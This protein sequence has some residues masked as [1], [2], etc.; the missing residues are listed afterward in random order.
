MKYILNINEW[1]SNNSKI[2]KNGKV[3]SVYHGTNSK[4]DKFDASYM[5]QTDDGYYGRGFY[6]TLDKEEAKDYGMN[7]I[8]ANLIVKNPFY[9]RTW[10]TVGSFVELDLRDDLAKLDGMPKDLKTNR[11]VPK[12]YYLKRWEH[13]DRGDDVVS[14]SVHPKEELYG[15]DDEI[16]GPDVNVLKKHDD[17]R[18]GEQA[19]SDFNDMQ[20]GIE[21]DGGLPN[22]LLQKV[23]RPNFHKILEKNGYDAIFVAGPEG[24]KTPI[25]EISEFIVWNPDQI[26][27]LN[28]I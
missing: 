23:D 17:K 1:S 11:T 7:I 22:W 14:Y 5:G 24:D 26:E 2:Y 3:L 9:L 4:F 25:E 6:F 19:I 13:N 28:N 16:Y 12:G 18:Y 15:T 21:Y 10:N 20:A 8:Q 27:I